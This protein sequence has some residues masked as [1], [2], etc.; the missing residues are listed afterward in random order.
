[1]TT[2]FIGFPPPVTSFP[3][4]DTLGEGCCVAASASVFRPV[5]SHPEA[6]IRL[7]RDVTIFENVRLLLGETEARLDIGD[8]VMINVGGYISGEGGLTIADDVLIGPHVRLLSAGHLIHGHHAA[9]ARNPISHGP[10]RIGRG[11]WLG[12]GAT[13]LE[14][15]VIGDG[16][17]VGA[18]SVVTRDVPPF[19]VVVGNPA[20][21]V[22]YRDGHRHDSDSWWRRLLRMFR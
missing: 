3:G 21:V 6:A 14:G 18:A 2:G 15:R 17:V 13:V 19:A 22:G 9:V 11:A 16:A 4:I 20:R 8:R 1:M 7:G 5:E 10:I 12:A